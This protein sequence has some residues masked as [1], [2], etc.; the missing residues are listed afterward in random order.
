MRPAHTLIANRAPDAHLALPVLEREL[1]NEARF[2]RAPEDVLQE[3]AVLPLPYT[4]VP[5][6]DGKVQTVL[7][8]SQ[9]RLLPVS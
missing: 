3:L 2:H 6:L 9:R 5:M 4:Q 1:F 8:T 7:V